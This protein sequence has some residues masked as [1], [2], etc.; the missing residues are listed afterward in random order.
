M[1]LC[2]KQHVL[3]IFIHQSKLRRK[4]TTKHSDRHEFFCFCEPDLKHIMLF[5]LRLD[6][7]A[8][9][10]LYLFFTTLKLKSPLL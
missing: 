3:N 2:L 9:P 1:S 4:K 6:V 10:D 5:A 7:P 8:Q